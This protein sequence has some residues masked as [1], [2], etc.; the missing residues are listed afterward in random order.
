MAKTQGVLPGMHILE[1]EIT[2]RCNLDC[3]HCYNR[4]RDIFDMPLKQIKN[5]FTL[6]E[7]AGIWTFI[8]SGGEAR[9]HPD[10]IK[11][12][13]F[14]KKRPRRF[15]LVLQTNGTGYKDAD[16]GWL[17]LFDLVHISYDVKADVR[18]G[19]KKNLALAKKLRDSGVNCYLFV[20]LHKKNFRQINKMVRDAGI[21]KIPIGF[22]VCLPAEHLGLAY[23]LNEKE[24]EKVEKKLFLLSRSR[25]ILRYS[26]PLIATL[27]LGKA[28]QWQGVRGG[29]TAG[30]GACVVTPNGDVLPCPFLRLSAGNINRKSL[31][32][33][34]LESSLFNLIRSR[35]K[36]AM[37]CGNCEYLSYCG[38]CRNRA[39]KKSGDIQGADPCCYKKN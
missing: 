37:P 26:S 33:I 7:K 14:I 28:G 15:R 39:Y 30:V 23:Q 19:A 34:W 10:F 36:F 8:V 38:G 2:T 16:S 24:F 35:R 3:R 18:F 4:R 31:H 6:G 27:D 1:V 17:K 13:Q 21:L 22:N 5:L 20:T 11:I 9:L 12:L 32:K 25:K 29:C